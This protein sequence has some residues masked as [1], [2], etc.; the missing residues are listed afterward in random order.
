MNDSLRIA[1]WI[2][3]QEICA[4][5]GTVKVVPATDSFKVEYQVNTESG[6][7]TE[8]FFPT[9]LEEVE[10]FLFGYRGGQGYKR[11]T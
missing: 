3:I 1:R 11:N 4:R 7:Y 9:T 10:A 8:Y 6:P 2:S 5:I